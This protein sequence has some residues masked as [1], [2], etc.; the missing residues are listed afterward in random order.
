MLRLEWAWRAL[1]QQKKMAGLV[2][3]K[4]EVQSQVLTLMWLQVTRKQSEER[5]L[6]SAQRPQRVLLVSTM[7]T[8]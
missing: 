7:E 2:Q 3:E 6:P 1:Q 4:C 8:D 5:R